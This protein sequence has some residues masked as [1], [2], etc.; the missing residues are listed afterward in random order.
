MKSGNESVM[1][2]EVVGAV[3]GDI[4]SRA[5]VAVHRDGNCRLGGTGVETKAGTWDS[6]VDHMTDEAHTGALPGYLGD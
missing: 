5:E 2:V 6:V 4:R 1:V 3:V